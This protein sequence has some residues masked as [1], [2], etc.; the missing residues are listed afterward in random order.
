MCAYILNWFVYFLYGCECCALHIEHSCWSASFLFDCWCLSMSFSIVLCVCVFI[1]CY[2]GELVQYFKPQ[3]VSTVHIINNCFEWL[4]FKPALVALSVTYVRFHHKCCCCYCM[5]GQR[6]G[7]L[8][9]RESY[10]LEMQKH[11]NIADFS[12][13][14]VFAILKWNNSKMNDQWMLPSNWII[15]CCIIFE[16]IVFKS[17]YNF[18]N[19]II[20]AYRLWNAYADTRH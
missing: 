8:S 12:H 17:S 10:R 3:I 6:F 20:I 15:E 13:A 5:N 14:N 2:R 18:V 16:P 11:T 7:Q 4:S 19:K 9:N 1:S